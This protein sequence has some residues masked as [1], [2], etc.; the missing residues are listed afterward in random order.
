MLTSTMFMM[1]MATALVFVLVSLASAAEFS[2]MVVSKAKGEEMQGKVFVKGDKMR[3]EINMDGQTNITITRPDKKVVWVAM[4]QQKMYMEMPLSDKMQQQ[5][6]LKDPEV[7]AR[8]KHLG[9]ETVNG[10]EC[11][12]YEMS[13]MVEGKTVTQHVWVAKKFG[14][15]IKSMTT[16]GS[17]SMEYRDIKVG[18]VADSVFEMPQGYQKMEMPSMK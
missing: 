12:K 8:M 17:M 2:A 14:L 1:G 7:R 10:Y 9:T 3:N 5:I 11:D 6:A 18:G 4:P 15:P 16:D 13:N